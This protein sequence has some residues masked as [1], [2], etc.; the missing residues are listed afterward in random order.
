MIGI[1]CIA[2]IK[3]SNRLQVCVGSERGSAWCPQILLIRVHQSLRP[4]LTPR[5]SAT[6]TCLGF[7]AGARFFGFLAGAEAKSR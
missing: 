7:R 6:K 4:I 3:N 2:P 1:D 5:L